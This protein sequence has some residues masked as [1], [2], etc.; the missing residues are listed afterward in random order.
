[1]FFSAFNVDSQVHLSEPEHLFKFLSLLWGY[2]SNLSDQLEFRVTA[3]LQTMALYVGKVLLTALPVKKLNILVSTSSS[4]TETLSPFTTQKTCKT[5]H[6]ECEFFNF[7]LH[8]VVPSLLGCLSCGVREVRKAAVEVLQPLAGV[9]S[10]PYHPLLEKLLQSAEELIADKSHLTQ[11]IHCLM[12]IAS[13]HKLKYTDN[14][15]YVCV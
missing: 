12:L 3:L 2:S 15:L 10:S 9:T 7:M 13:T 4:G 11:V 5:V 6:S 14:A 8:A 1:M